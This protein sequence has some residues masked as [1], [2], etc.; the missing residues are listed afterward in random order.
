MFYKDTRKVVRKGK[1]MKIGMIGSTLHVL[2]NKNVTDKKGCLK[3]ITKEGLKDAA[4]LYGTTA[5]I[6]GAAAAAVKYSPKA[7]QVANSAIS[8]VK[9]YAKKVFSADFLGKA[10]EFYSK[11]KLAGLPK[12][13]KIGIAAGAAAFSIITPILLTHSA[14]KSAQIEKSYEA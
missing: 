3:D 7:S 10:K 1:Y 14:Q 8:A 11:T 9:G 12:L 4:V 2:T 13:A 5:A 6:G